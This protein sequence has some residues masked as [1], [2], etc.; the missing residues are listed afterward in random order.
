MI[1][2]NQVEIFLEHYGVKGMQR[3]SKSPERL[4]RIA[5][6]AS[7]TEARNKNLQAAIK[8][9]LKA[10]NDAVEV[11]DKKNKEQELKEFLETFESEVQAKAAAFIKEHSDSPVKDFTSTGEE[12]SATSN[13]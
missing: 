2:D 7:G 4:N 11:E 9:K 8:A 3:K 5:R 6:V 1:A 13:K 12:L 10:I